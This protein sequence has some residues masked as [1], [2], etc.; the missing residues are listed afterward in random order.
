LI[1]L[2][3]TDPGLLTPPSVTWFLRVRTPHAAST[4]QR[5]SA[6]V[7]SARNRGTLGDPAFFGQV[8]VDIQSGTVAWPGSIDLAPEPLYELARAHPLVAA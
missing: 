2:R 6:A 4:R 5:S 7:P 3:L 1:S 8:T